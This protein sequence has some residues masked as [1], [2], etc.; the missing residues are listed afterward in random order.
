M[1]NSTLATKQIK[2]LLYVYVSKDPDMQSYNPYELI[3][4]MIAIH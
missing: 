4:Y 2:P 3:L 1:A